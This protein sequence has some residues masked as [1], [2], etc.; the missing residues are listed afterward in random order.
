MRDAWSVRATRCA[1]CPQGAGV[2]GL[3]SQQVATWHCQ[4]KGLRA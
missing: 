3:K 1:G 2:F 4:H